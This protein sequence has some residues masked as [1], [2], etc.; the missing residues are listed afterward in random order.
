MDD[1]VFSSYARL[2]KDAWRGRSTQP[3]VAQML[4]DSILDSI[5]W[6]LTEDEPPANLD[7]NSASDLFLRKDNVHSVVV[8]HKNDTDVVSEI[9]SYFVDIVIPK[10]EPSRAPALV[11]NLSTLIKQSDR[12][13]PIK[14]NLLDSAINDSPAEF[15]SASYLESLARDNKL[16]KA[17]STSTPDSS[18]S[19]P[20]F[21]RTAYDA[22]KVPNDIQF[23][24]IP[25]INALLEAYGDAENIE[26]VEIAFLSNHPQLKNYK[27]HFDRQRIDY[28]NADFVRHS[29]RGTLD[30]SGHGA[31]P[32]L[33]LEIH[34]GIIDTYE[35]NFPNGYERLRACLK[36]AGLTP[37]SRS[38]L[39]E[40]Q[41]WLSVSVKKGVCHILI[42]DNVLDGWV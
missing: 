34:D 21:D 4:Y 40:H 22:V 20:A 15:L 39:I 6:D 41:E 11:T 8:C 30:S 2:I 27:D 23:A 37:V 26:K 24:E 33:E 9:Q 14:R 3:V 13:N 29:T 18:T 25:Y 16:T 38:W 28:F 35:E 12:P 1:Y 42:N 17:E 10:L 36:A 19:I 32:D 31:F 5:N 7:K